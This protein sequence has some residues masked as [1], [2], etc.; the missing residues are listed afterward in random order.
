MPTC[1]LHYEHDQRRQLQQVPLFTGANEGCGAPL[2]P[3]APR[4]RSL[5]G[6]QQPLQQRIADNEVHIHHGH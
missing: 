6:A 4:V 1:T 5:F 2:T 3:P